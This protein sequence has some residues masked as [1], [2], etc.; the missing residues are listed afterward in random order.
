MLY[1]F[2]MLTAGP[3]PPEEPEQATPMNAL[4][5]VPLPPNTEPCESVAMDACKPKA[6]VLVVPRHVFAFVVES[7]MPEVDCPKQFVALTVALSPVPEVEN[8]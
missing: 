7:P 5:P 1:L 8:P 6:P 4:I 3:L 2:A